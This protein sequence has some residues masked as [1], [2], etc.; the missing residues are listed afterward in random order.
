MYNFLLPINPTLIIV[1]GFTD[2][3][4]LKS[5]SEGT[6]SR[7]GYTLGTVFLPPMNL[8]H[9][10]ISKSIG[11]SE[12]FEKVSILGG[13]LPLSPRELLYFLCKF[14]TITNF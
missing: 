13:F 8:T 6:L 5:S 11:N 3:I 10:L 9:L 14:S 4:I 7:D 1:I 12:G 2:M